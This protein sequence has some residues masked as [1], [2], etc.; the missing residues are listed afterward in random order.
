MRILFVDIAESD[1]EVIRTCGD[2]GYLVDSVQNVEE[3]AAVLKTAHPELVFIALRAQ[4]EWRDCLPLIKERAPEAPIVGLS[5]LASGR[6]KGLLA[7]SGFSSADF[8]DFMDL[9]LRL[10]EILIAIETIASITDAPP[11]SGAE[12]LSAKERKHRL[13]LRRRQLDARIM[14]KFLAAHGRNDE[15]SWQTGPDA[16]CEQE[17]TENCEGKTQRDPKEAAP[18]NR[19]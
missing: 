2:W 10:E 12:R 1:A 16:P 14:S 15:F 6:L 13:G 19:D 9:P 17:L 18:G 8:A 11:V 7:G 5:S 4:G 3:C